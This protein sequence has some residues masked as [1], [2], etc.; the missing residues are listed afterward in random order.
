MELTIRLPADPEKQGRALTAHVL[1]TPGRGRARAMATPG[2]VERIDP[3][4]ERLARF[5]NAVE[6]TAAVPGGLPLSAGFE[7]RMFGISERPLP[8]TLIV[9]LDSDR[10]LVYSIDP[11]SLEAS[12][13]KE[14]KKP[15]ASLLSGPT[16]YVR[17]AWNAA[18]D[19]KDPARMFFA[20]L[21]RRTH[22]QLVDAFYQTLASPSASA[23]WRATKLAVAALMVGLG[24]HLRSRATRPDGV[25]TAG[26]LHRHLV[27]HT[28]YVGKLFLSLARKYFPDKLGGIDPVGF[29]RAFE[30]FAL[31]EL[32]YKLP[33]GYTT[34]QPSSGYFVFFGE[35]A[36]FCHASG[37]EPETWK[38]L[39]RA[40][41]RTQEAFFRV[42][43]PG[44]TA[45]PPYG[46]SDYGPHTYDAQAAYDYRA[47]G[48]LDALYHEF[49]AL[50][51][52]ELARRSCGYVRM[53]MS[54]MLGS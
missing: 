38:A 29:G 14:I 48:R 42:H 20:D 17:E 5:P 12:D 11:R 39:S 15:A 53:Y 1:L 47:S 54:G 51:F 45:A 43:A 50:E 13:P 52:P 31:G 22:P 26:L 9:A 44:D 33:S 7:L 34:A 32:A 19:S 18:A 8:T 40:M 2:V 41:I 23:D 21:D 46:I 28:R 24:S 35:L 27:S 10:S 6:Y 25:V 16:D 37:Y 30:R 4:A 3:S 49:E 36:M